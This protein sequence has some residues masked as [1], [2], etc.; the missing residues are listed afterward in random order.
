MATKLREVA[1]ATPNSS[2]PNPLIS[3]EKLRQLYSAM[4]KCRLLSERARIP[5]KLAGLENEH[6]SSAG[7]E[8]TAVGAAI[9]LRPGDAVAT[10]HRDLILSYLKGVPLRTIFNQLHGRNRR[11]ENVRSAPDDRR[12]TQWNIIPAASNVTAQ[13]ERC[14]D[15]A[16]ANQRKKNDTVVMAFCG[17]D[18][19]PLNHWHDALRFAGR[20]SLPIVFV[21]PSHRRGGSDAASIESAGDDTRSEAVGFG[22]PGITVDGNDAV[23]VYRVA[24]EAVERARSGGNPTLI[25]AQV[26]SENGSS[27]PITAMERHLTGKGIFSEDWKKEIIAGFQRELGSAVAETDS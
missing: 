23:A 14:I 27:D 25:E 19:V 16:F 9:D 12:Y 10:P 24:H 21:R 13:L 11:P 6:S 3:H 8:A 15:V 4:L 7:L 2:L 1:A 5:E 22:F 17:G 26:F 20:R 18:S